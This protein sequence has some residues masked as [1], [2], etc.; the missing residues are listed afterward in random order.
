MGRGDLEGEI[1]YFSLGNS[2]WGGYIE[3]GYE[4]W[5]GVM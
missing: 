1:Y 2:D 4:W 3:L 5:E